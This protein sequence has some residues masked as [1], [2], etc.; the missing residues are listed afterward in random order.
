MDSLTAMLSR[1]TSAQAAARW[2][3]QTGLPQQFQLT[4]EIDTKDVSKYEPLP[5]P[6]KW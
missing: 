5:V 1:P 6:D 4:T 2:F 3:V